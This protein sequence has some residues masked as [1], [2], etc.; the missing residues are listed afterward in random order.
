MTKDI[1]TILEEG[2][3]VVLEGNCYEMGDKGSVWVHPAWDIVSLRREKGLEPL[4][5][6]GDNPSAKKIVGPIDLEIAT[7]VARGLVA[8]FE[9]YGFN[10][11]YAVVGDD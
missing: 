4:P 3:T 8:A 7:N 10:V 9:S 6:L 1:E 11:R 5:D 2:I